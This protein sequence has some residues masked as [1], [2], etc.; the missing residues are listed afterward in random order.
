M[1]SIN[2]GNPKGKH[3]CYSEKKGEWIIF[4]CPVC[5]DFERKVHSITGEMITTIDPDN[6]HLHYGTHVPVGLETNL[7]NPN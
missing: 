3:K 7:Y 4:R 6:T 1:A 5:E 2:F